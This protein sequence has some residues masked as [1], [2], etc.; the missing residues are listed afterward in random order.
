MSK[1]IWGT[2]SR[3]SGVS[4]DRPYSVTRVNTENGSMVVISAAQTA[5]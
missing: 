1:N 5:W 2:A 4:L 3:A